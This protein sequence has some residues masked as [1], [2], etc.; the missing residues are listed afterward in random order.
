M[1]LTGTRN[2]LSRAEEV[3]KWS[4]SVRRALPQRDGELELPQPELL[5]ELFRLPGLEVA[6]AGVQLRGQRHAPGRPHVAPVVRGAGSR[7]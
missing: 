3:V 5:L 4:T 1:V 7:T 6:Q 2:G